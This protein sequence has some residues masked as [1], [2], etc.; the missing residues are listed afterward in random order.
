MAGCHVH[1]VATSRRLLVRTARALP[2]DRRVVRWVFAVVCLLLSSIGLYGVVAAHV[3]ERTREVGIRVALGAPKSLVLRSVLIEGATMTLIGMVG[4]ATIAA[5]FSNWLE[6]L[7]YGVSRHDLAT[8]V[9]VAVLMCLVTGVATYI[10]ARRASSV[11]PMK[12]LREQ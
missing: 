5:L 6:P 12:A 1:V 4:G 11:E 8:I 2:G 9:G 7:L 3:V 10:P